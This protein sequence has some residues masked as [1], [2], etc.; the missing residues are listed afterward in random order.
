MGGLPQRKRAQTTP[1]AFTRLAYH[2]LETVKLDTRASRGFSQWSLYER[3]PVTTSFGSATA[4]H[5]LNT[6]AYVSQSAST[7]STTHSEYSSQLRLLSRQVLTLIYPLLGP[8]YYS[9]CF[10][11][12]NFKLDHI[13]LQ[14]HT[15]SCTISASKA[16]CDRR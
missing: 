12:L 7:T 13:P 15:D 9:R 16:L 5:H 3:L 8:A 2:V 14:K 4:L 6:F 10:H 1:E 11:G